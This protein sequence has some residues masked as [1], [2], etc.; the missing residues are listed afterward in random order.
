MSFRTLMALAA[1][2][3]L[4]LDQMDAINAFVNCPL[5]EEE[6]V[7]MKM[8]PG[9]ERRVKF[10]G[11]EKPSMDFAEPCVM[12]K[13]AVIVFF[14]VDDIIWAY[15]KRDQQ[16]ATEAKSGLQQRYKMSILGNLNAYIDK[17]AHKYVPDKL[18]IK[19]PSTLMA[20]N[21]E[22]LSEPIQ[23]RDQ[24]KHSYL[25]KQKLAEFLRLIGLEEIGERLRLEARLEALKDK[26][27]D[28]REHRMRP[29]HDLHEH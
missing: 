2:Y 3:D 18:G 29:S 20:T 6:V 27:K 17:I 26:I 28:C 25:Q 9:F 16:V 19:L 21:E 7:F 8:P 10:Y 5:E 22:L 14:Y 15:R 24:D 13:G 1:E 12:M 11:Y 4:E 23:A